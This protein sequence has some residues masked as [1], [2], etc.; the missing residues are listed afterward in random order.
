[1]ALLDLE[2]EGVLEQV[3][4]HLPDQA[5]QLRSTCRL[6]RRSAGLLRCTKTLVLGGNFS[7]S[8]DIPFLLQL[9]HLQSLHVS[10]PSSLAHLHRL[11]SLTC[12]QQLSIASDQVQ[13]MAALCILSQLR[14]LV[15]KLSREPLNVADITHITGLELRGERYISA[16]EQLTGLK[17]LILEYKFP[18][19][20]ALTQLT[21][22]DFGKA[23][24]NNLVSISWQLD[25]LPDLR[26]LS[27]E[28][29]LLVPALRTSQLTAVSLTISETT[30]PLVFSGL[31][32]LQRLALQHTMPWEFSLA[33][34]RVSFLQLEAFAAD[35]GKATCL[36][37]L[38]DCPSLQHIKVLA[39]DST[40]SIVSA[41]LPLHHVLISA[42]VD[43]GQ[44]IA[45]FTAQR[46]QLHF[47]DHSL[48]SDW[49]ARVPSFQ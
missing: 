38:A 5:L 41:Q 13:D 44:V 37:S 11:S 1:M 24:I 22:I 6:L 14:D 23:A 35:A 16:V 9:T 17:R 32:S 36:P 2:P 12:M 29:G 49:A 27:A 19:F 43:K 34:P 42:L 4:Q 8:Q 20:H 40:V 18:G 26:V 25:Q 45:H 3:A 15:L 30:V 48:S 7:P 31:P 46:F 33:L 10:N 28:S 47:Y 21:R 39:H